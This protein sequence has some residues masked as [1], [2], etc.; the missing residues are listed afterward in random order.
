MINIATVNITKLKDTIA[1]KTARG[2]HIDYLI[3]NR[4]TLEYVA[5]NVAF[6]DSIL[7]YKTDFIMYHTFLGIKIALCEAL[8]FGEVDFV[9]KGES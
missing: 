2:Q 7:T 1:I 3:M 5:F 9:Q 8:D 4:E 6:K